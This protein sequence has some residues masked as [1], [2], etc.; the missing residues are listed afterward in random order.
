MEEITI[1]QM[2]EGGEE[3]TAEVFVEEIGQTVNTRGGVGRFGHEG[4]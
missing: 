3:N 1:H 4:V 2:G